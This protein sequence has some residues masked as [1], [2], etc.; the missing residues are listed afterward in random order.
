MMVD[1][2]DIC[3]SIS[4]RKGVSQ[5]LRLRYARIRANSVLKANSYLWVSRMGTSA[6]WI[7]VAG[8]AC[9]LVL[10]VYADNDFEI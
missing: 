3:Y 4:C 8:L 10:S 9:I 1:N 7:A 2:A 6:L 5:Y